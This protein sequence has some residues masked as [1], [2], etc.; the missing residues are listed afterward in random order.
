[1]TSKETAQRCRKC[2]R[3]IPDGGQMLCMGVKP[4]ALIDDVTDDDCPKGRVTPEAPADKKRPGRKSKAVKEPEA[5]AAGPSD[6]SGQAQS[7]P[8]AR[9]IAVYRPRREEIRMHDDWCLIAAM[10]GLIVFVAM[11]L[12]WVAG[13]CL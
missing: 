6:R 9:P 11:A 2:D 1:M 5:K 7:E 10:V 3:A 12:L 8:K 13:G 4:I